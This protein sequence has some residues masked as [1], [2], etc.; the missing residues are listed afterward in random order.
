M[1]RSDG[2]DD[3][4]GIRREA[5]VL[6]SCAALFEQRQDAMPVPGHAASTRN[7]NECRHGSGFYYG[8]RALKTLEHA[9][10]IEMSRERIRILDVDALGVWIDS[11]HAIAVPGARASS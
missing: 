1:A 3:T 7:E 10:G 5:R 4:I 8:Q 9:A 2:V 11:D 6:A